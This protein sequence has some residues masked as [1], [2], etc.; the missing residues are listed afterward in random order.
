MTIWDDESSRVFMIK[1]DPITPGSKVKYVVTVWPD[2]S[3]LKFTD[4]MISD[5]GS[6]G[7]AY[8][9]DEESVSYF[10]E[11]IRENWEDS[12]DAE[13]EQAMQEFFTE[14]KKIEQELNKTIK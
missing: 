6:F 13:H 3:D 4:W 14:Q 10:I 12:P 8:T 2:G 5:V 1:E 9:L 7:P 11:K